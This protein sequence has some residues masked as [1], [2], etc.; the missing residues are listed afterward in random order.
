MNRYKLLAAAACC[1]LGLASSE[2]R[3][4]TTG[5]VTGHVIDHAGQPLAGANITIPAARIGALSDD[6]GAYTLLGVT[7]GTY[8]LHAAMIGHRPVTVTSVIVSADRTT[9]I[10]V[11]L[12]DEALNLKGVEV[13]AKRPLVQSD[14]TS[15]RF[16]V[17]GEDIARLPV[18][19]L[20]EVVNLQAG[21][22]NG[23]I[24]GGRSGEVQYQV[25]G[26]SVNN[27]YDNSAGIQL[28]RSVL[29]EV[30]VI[31]GTFDAEY[32][33]AMSGVV[34][35]VLK[36]GGDKLEWSGETYAGDFVFPSDAARPTVDLWRPFSLNQVQGTLSGPTGLPRTNFLLSARHGQNDDYFEGRRW[37]EPDDRSDFQNKIF[38]GSGD[39]SR[40]VLAYTHEWSGVAKVSNRS[41]PNVT[42]SYEALWNLI[43]GRR[44]GFAWRL[45]PD[46][47]AKQHT[48]NL[49]HGFDW[50]QRLSSKSFYNV[51]IRQNLVRYRDMVFES[52]FDPRYDLAGPPKSDPSYQLGSIVQ[53][54]D[55]TRFIQNTNAIVGKASW[56]SQVSRYHLVKLGGELQYPDVRFGAPGTISD[57]G[58]GLVRHVDDPL[59]TTPGARDFPGVQEYRPVLAAAFAQDQVEWRDLTMRGGLRMD[60]FD[61]RSRIPTDLAN[62]A[63]DIPG[64]PHTDYIRPHR[65]VSLAPRF[66]ISYPVGNRAAVFFSYG[67]FYQLPSISDIFT[68]SDYTVLA[69]LQAKQS[70]SALGNPDIKPQFTS[71]YEFGYK[72]A[73]TE[74]LGLDFTVFYKDIRD[75]IGVEFIETYAA[76]EYS[77]LTNVDFGNVKGITLALDRR[78]YGPLSAT[79]DYTW[80]VAEGNTSDPRETATR[81]ETGQDPRPRLIPLDWDQRHTLNLTFTLLGASGTASAIVRLVS[82]QPYTP[83]TSTVSGTTVSILEA[84]SG[85]KPNGLLVDLRGERLLVPEHNFRVFARVFNAFDTRSFNGFVFDDTGSPDYTRTP[86]ST[87]LTTLADPTRFQA[88]RR[89]EVGVSASGILNGGGGK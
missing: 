30:Q 33:Q 16:V 58:T 1:L 61:S 6:H 47:M 64:A 8:E 32:G 37:F 74:D 60:Y 14:L 11:T 69:G 85:R 25:S 63:N 2:S 87:N 56:T 82:G 76:G 22:V 3:A 24:R 35:A 65:K 29:Q 40:V 62:P 78:N 48:M 49:V 9:T 52:V 21:V 46:G 4:G 41:I 75:L 13:V 84:N 18:Q 66:G 88:P 51:S 44:G 89:I 81:A 31:S 10:D 39:S 79:L 28:D 15:T 53:G 80:E 5:K 55:L 42:A 43:D 83:A 19:D 12:E 67:H 59:T 54:V 45:N 20:Q 7:A 57:I 23:H 36:S 17:R 38:R 26:V 72:H 27:L 77:R 86:S 34:N 71:Q 50:N 73:I 68:N 70:F